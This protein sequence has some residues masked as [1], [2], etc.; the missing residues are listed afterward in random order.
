[1]ITELLTDRLTA[2]E[3][4]EIPAFAAS[5]DW[6]ANKIKS[7]PIKLY[8]E[9]EEGTK[10]IADDNR[11]RYLNDASDNDT[12][13]ASE[14]KNA[15]VRDYLLTGRG[16]AFLDLAYNTVSG[17]HYVKSSDVSYN[18]PVDP[19]FRSTTY[20]INGRSYMPFR[21]LRILRHTRDGVRGY[22]VIDENSRMLSIAYSTMQFEEKLTASGGCRK[23]YLQA[24]K[25]LEEGAL[26]KLKAA[27][28]KLWSLDGDAAIVLNAG[29]TVKEAS[30]SPVELQM[31]ENKTTNAGQIYEI[32]LLSADIIKGTANA[33]EVANA[34]QNA[35]I[36]IV[37]D[38]EGALNRDL[39]LESEK[40]KR[41]FAFDLKELLKGDIVKRYRAYQIALASNFMQLDEVRYS[42]DLPPLG[43]N[44]IKLGLNDVL[45]DPVK[46]TIYTPNTN[47]LTA[48]GDG[49]LMQNVGEARADDHRYIQG[50]DG[51]MNGSKPSK[52]GEGIDKSTESGI[53]KTKKQ[54]GAKLG[55]HYKDFGID[56]SKA[57][58][59][60]KFNDIIDDIVINHDVPVKIGDWR[61]QK[62]EV[63]FFAK[64]KNV[65]ILKQN[66][67]FV[68]ILEGG[69]SNERFKNARDK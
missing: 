29:V 38:F 36:P 47:A 33:D 63:L 41:Y 27:W 42:E 17:I 65:V 43:V 30:S 2:K 46:Q 32:F 18:S 19:I 58:D 56:P 45:Y 8:E 10:E 25:K 50:K 3:A 44:F 9:T 6:I 21:L 48:L 64:G 31:N 54:F 7:L 59:R 49:G 26:A 23:A 68:T 66:Y 22:S 52:S 39:L 53:I 55:R 14:M 12:M 37:S 69:V 1:M 57:E 4:M 60:E 40:G 13:I 16:Y 34:V 24:E 20:Y 61:G 62:E 28:R 67:E 15:M 11:V 51:K 5:V 35:I